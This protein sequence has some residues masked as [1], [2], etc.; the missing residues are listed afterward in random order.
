LTRN[1]DRSKLKQP[2]EVAAATELALFEPQPKRRY[3]VV[4]R[5]DE[6]EITIKAQIQQL[7]QLNE[8]QLICGSRE[9]TLQTT[10]D[11]GIGLF[12]RAC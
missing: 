5:Q 4:P 8:D 9:S 2:D 11:F 6:A 12:G 1:G 3:V 7:V 10:A